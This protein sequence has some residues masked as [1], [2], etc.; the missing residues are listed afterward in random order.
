MDKSERFW[1]KASKNYDTTEDRFE[2]IHSRVRDKTKVHL[3]ATDVV[4]DYGCGTGTKVCE[5]AGFVSEVLGIDISADMIELAKAKGAT[6]ALKNVCF[7]QSTIFDETLKDASFDVVMAFNMLH[8]VPSPESVVKRI[9]EVLKPG[10][11]FISVTPCMAEKKSFFVSLQIGIFRLLSKIG[12]VPISFEFYGS[13]DVDGLVGSKGFQTI[14]S[15]SIFA[16][17]TSY[18]VVVKKAGELA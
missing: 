3:S 16:G 9:H 4:L 12:L 2:E 14:E 7:K 13:S 15:E 5:L 1:D 18:F 10:G 11:L 17:A 6:H 8:T